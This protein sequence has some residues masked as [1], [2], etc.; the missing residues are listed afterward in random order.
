MVTGFDADP[1]TNL[2]VMDKIKEYL[3]ELDIED[4]PKRAS[5]DDDEAIDR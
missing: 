2:S 3:E 1:A 4:M 5:D